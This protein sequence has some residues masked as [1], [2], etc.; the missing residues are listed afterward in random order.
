M[1]VPRRIHDRGQREPAGA[2]GARTVSRA[3]PLL[4]EIDPRWIARQYLRR[5]PVE[6]LR[7][8]L[9]RLLP[10]SRLQAGRWDLRTI[11]CE[12][13]PTY[14]L[15]AELHAAD[16]V[17]ERTALYRRLLDAARAGRPE[18]R[19][20]TVLVDEEA[21][22]RFFG[23]YVALFESMAAHG[24]RPG[25]SKDEPGIAIGRAGEPIKLANGNHRFAVARLLGLR[26]IPAEVHFVHPRWY[27]AM[28]R[29]PQRLRRAVRA[30][31]GVTALRPAEG[32][33]ARNPG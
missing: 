15:L 5:S 20:G 26:P 29:G 28:P 33:P 1:P 4:V 14:R 17:P 27:A 13:H 9:L 6:K 11:A 7:F 23:D 31:A 16:L 21:I 24:Y 2:A 30:A 32:A 3:G 25:A 10:P 12:E 22:R 8:G 18:Q 19:R